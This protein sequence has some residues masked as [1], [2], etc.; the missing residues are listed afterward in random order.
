MLV[1]KTRSTM[2]ETCMVTN[3]FKNQTF[4]K[5]PAPF[6]YLEE[7]SL[8]I[9]TRATLLTPENDVD[10]VKDVDLHDNLDEFLQHR[11]GVQIEGSVDHEP[12]ILEESEDFR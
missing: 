6:L 11:E 5:Y 1:I 12:P 10:V 3:Y 7:N 4:K 2:I 9:T 8:W